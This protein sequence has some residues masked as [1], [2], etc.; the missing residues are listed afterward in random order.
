MAL[1]YILSGFILLGLCVFVHEL[2]HLLGG[3]MVGIKAKVFSLGYGKGIIKKK[4]GDTTYQITPIPFGGYCK[5]YGEEPGEEREGK[6]FEFLSASPVRRIIVV[7]MGPLFNL[8]F[9]IL[10]FLT[11]NLIGF[12][13]ETNRVLVP[14]SSVGNIVSPAVKAG[15]KDG[16]R[17]IDINGTAIRDFSGI[18]ESVILSEG[19]E[20]NVR[21][22]RGNELIDLRIKPEK[23]SEKD[24]YEIGI[25][26][27]GEEVLIGYVLEGDIAQKAGLKSMDI[28]KS[29][30]GTQIKNAEEYIDIIRKNPDNEL[31]MTVIRS[32]KEHIIKITPRL[33]EV[34][35]IN[36]F[37]DSRFKNEKYD[38]ILD[39]IDLVKNAISQKTLK[40]NDTIIGSLDQLKKLIDETKNKTVTLTNS[41]GI[42]T[43]NISYDSYGFIGV[44]TGVSPEMIHM[45]YGIG[46]SAKRAVVEPFNFIV[47]NVK[48]MGM[49]FSG[50]LDVRE[51]LS[52]PVRIFKLAGDVAYYKG[53]SAFILLM[54]RISVILMVMNLLPIPVVDGSMILFFLLEAVRGKPI[55]QSVME[56]IQYVGVIFLIALGVFIIFN[57]LSFLPFIQKFFN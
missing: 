30:N 3:K 15:L 8:I 47:M 29:I 40:I 39:K 25:M 36:Q 50:K 13:T 10:L 1:T 32:G 6:G 43:G 2:G 49:L 16:D 38:I 57:D 26:P 14:K 33:R 19:K 54:A 45:R 44:Q 22:E 9:G 5:F 31:T 12:S 35:T 56:R 34:L 23:L 51:N 37:E 53:I 24:H 55:N 46:E 42:Y 11:M 4:I 20:M 17:I 48:A 21:A 28:V 27:F 52:G 18:L 7:I 41:G